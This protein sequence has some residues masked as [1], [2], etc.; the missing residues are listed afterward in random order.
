MYS[1]DKTVAE[2]QKIMLEILKEIHRICVKHNLTY[3]LEAGTLLGAVRHKG[4]IP[5]DDDCDISM[6]RVDY[7]R[8]IEIAKSELP[9]NMFLQSK[10]TDPASNFDAIKIRKLGT[11]L[12]ETGETGNEEYCHGI[13]VDVFPYDSY[14]DEWFIELLKWQRLSREKRKRYPKGS[15]K[16]LLATIYVNIIMWLP[17]HIIGLMK[18]FA[19]KKR[20]MYFNNKAHEYFSYG[21]EC[22][23]PVK[24]KR[25]DILPV[26]LQQ[27]CF[28]DESFYLPNNPD[29]VLR[30]TYGNDYMTPPPI[31]K[32]ATHA[33]IIKVNTN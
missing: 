4:F 1:E 32:R 17:I 5:W 33:K 21:L 28:E 26:R 2:A 19:I 14:K 23:Y 7:E 30:A 20:N 3:W 13:F 27:R 31:D 10:E 25:S 6:P 15:I 11:V 22:F 18:N 8:F 16:R 9:D 12:I 29:A 24:T